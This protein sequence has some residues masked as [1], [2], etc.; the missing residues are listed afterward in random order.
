MY[1]LCKCSQGHSKVGPASF[2]LIYFIK[3]KAL[4]NIRIKICVWFH[5]SAAGFFYYFDDSITVQY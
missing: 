1:G 2:H 5:L 4:E 3:I